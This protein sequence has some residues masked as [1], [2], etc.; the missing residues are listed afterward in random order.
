MRFHKASSPI[1]A[2]V[3]LPLD[4]MEEVELGEKLLRCQNLWSLQLITIGGG[5]KYVLFS[6][7]LILGEMIQSD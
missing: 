7:L 1:P 5:F 3:N 6:P 2:F 4:E